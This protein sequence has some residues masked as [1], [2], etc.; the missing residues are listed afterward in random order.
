MANALY[1]NYKNKLLGNGTHALADWDTDDIRATLTDH[2]VD[3]PVVATDQDYADI[4]AGEIANTG[5]TIAGAALCTI[6]AGGVDIDD[7]AFATVSG[8]P[9]ESI[10]FYLYDA[11]PT[12]AALLVFIDTATGLPI[13]PNG[14]DINVVIDASGL[15]TF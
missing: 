7:F 11:T 8:D 13:T 9:A 5:A 2:A 3:T 15:F 10:T 1:T 4:S 6:S 12:I 14:A